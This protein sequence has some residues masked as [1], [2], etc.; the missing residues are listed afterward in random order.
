MVN[1]LESALNKNRIPEQR[2]SHRNMSQEDVA[3]STLLSICR[4]G[5]VK[6]PDLRTSKNT[7]SQLREKKKN[8]PII[9]NKVKEDMSN[10]EKTKWK[11]ED[12]TERKQ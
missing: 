3:R 4:E 1:D 11:H 7:W 6:N 10:R 2:I 8:T 9:G 5:K 12:F